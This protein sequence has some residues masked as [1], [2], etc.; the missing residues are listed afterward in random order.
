MEYKVIDGPEH[1]I[2]ATVG[3]IPM[4]D[5]STGDFLG[6]GHVRRCIYDEDLVH[7]LTVS[8]SFVLRMFTSDERHDTIPALTDGGSTD[9]VLGDTEPG[10]TDQAPAG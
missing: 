10:R 6:T 5:L 8:G 3:Y 7:V 4:I 9:G 1:L 2:G